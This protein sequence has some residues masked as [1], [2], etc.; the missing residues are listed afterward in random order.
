LAMTLKD[1]EEGGSETEAA[2]MMPTADEMR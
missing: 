1:K 2:E